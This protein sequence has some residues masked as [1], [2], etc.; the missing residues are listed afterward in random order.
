MPI[1]YCPGGRTGGIVQRIAVPARLVERRRRDVAQQLVEQHGSRRGAERAPDVEAGHGIVHDHLDLQHRLR[2]CRDGRRRF[3]GAVTQ[4]DGDDLGGR[5]RV[6]LVH[7]LGHVGGR[8]PHVLV[9][10]PV[11]RPDRP[12]SSG[13]QPHGRRAQPHHGVHVVADEEDGPATRL[14]LAH[15]PEALALELDVADGQ[16]LVDEQ[17]LGLHVG[18]DGEAEA[19]VHAR[20]VA[21]DGRVHEP[22]E[23][24]ELDDRVELTS[25]LA[26]AHPE[27]RAVQV[28]VLESRSARRGTR[29]RPRAASRCGPASGCGPPSAW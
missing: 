17:D 15:L 14:D 22:L 26:A 9:H 3:A 4:R 7:H 18:G 21:L 16:H 8:Q 13:L 6:G 27:D 29:C 11:R 20:A 5:R 25:D 12:N 10:Q 28:G 23:A 1:A 2:S 24:G 19:Q